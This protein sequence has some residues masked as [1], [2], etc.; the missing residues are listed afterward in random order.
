MPYVECT[1]FAEAINTDF[2]SVITTV[3]LRFIL[4]H[5]V[6]RKMYTIASYI[7]TTNP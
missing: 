1:S 2:V 7:V 4:S 3:L 6:H 5:P